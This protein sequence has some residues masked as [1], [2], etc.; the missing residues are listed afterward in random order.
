MIHTIRSRAA[1]SLIETMIAVAV[2]GIT[3]MAAM[4]LVRTAIVGN[5][6]VEE[7]LIAL[8]LALEAIESVKNIRDTN[9]L[10]FASNPDECWNAINADDV[11]LCS[12]NQIQASPVF[13]T[14]NRN[15]SPALG[16]MFEWTLEEGSDPELDGSV[17]LYEIF[18][19][20][21][22]PKPVQIYAQTG[23]SAPFIQTLDE[24]AYQRTM[25]FNYNADGSLEASVTVNW[26]LGS[27]D[28]TL[29]ITRTIAN[30]Q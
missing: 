7:K 18:I 27:Q 29:T 23:F 22:M 11:S 5:Q 12:I 24:D 28:R 1:E 15:M 3:T 14:L 4:S 19:E 21:S 6:V 20:E 8:N 2:I 10:R 30:I 13:Y 26:I 16:P 17:N 9:Y 25:E